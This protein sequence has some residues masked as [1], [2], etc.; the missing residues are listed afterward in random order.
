MAL[1][2]FISHSTSDKAVSDA[3]C[4][5]LENA[6]IRCWVAPRDV[7]PGRSFAGEITR[8]I[9]QSKVM[10]LI[11]S[12]HSNN[13]EQ[14]LRE[15]QLATNAHLHIVQFRIEDVVLNDDLKYFLSTPH[16]LDALSQPLENHLE[17]LETSIKSLLGTPVEEPTKSDVTTVSSFV[18][19]SAEVG[20]RPVVEKQEPNPFA[21]SP[22]SKMWK[23]LVIAVIVICAGA[24]AGW[25]FGVYQPAR[26]AHPLESAQNKPEAAGAT[27]SVAAGTVRAELAPEA[28]ASMKNGSIAAQQQDY[29]LAL[30][31]FQDARKLAPDTPEVFYNL[32][33]AESK[34]PERELRA[35]AWFGAY[36]AANSPAPNAAAVKDQMGVLDVRSQSNVLRLIKSVQDSANEISGDNKD[37]NLEHV[38]ELWAK[39]GDIAA[40][41][42]TADLLESDIS[43]RS[44]LKKIASTQE[45]AGD[46][47]G[48][49]KTADLIQ[50]A[51]NKSS[52]Q[53]DIAKAQAKAGDIAGAQKTADLIQDAIY[54]REAQSAIAEVQ[55]KA[56]DIAGAQNTLASALKT[57]DLIQD[58]LWKSNAKTAIAEAQIKTGDMTG[59]Q[60]T[61][62]SARKTADLIQDALWKSSGYSFIAAAQARGGDIPGAQKTADLIQYSESKGSAQTAIAEGQIKAGD[63]SGARNTLLSAERTVDLI[64][65][66]R[67]KRI[68]QSAIAEAQIK[69]GDIAGA[70]IT[71]ASALKTAGLIQDAY[72][73]SYAQTA[74]AEAQIKAGEIAGAKTTLASALKSADL[75]QD[76]A[77]WKSSAQSFVAVAYA[78]TGDVAGAQKIADLIQ[79]ASYKR[80]AQEAIA[81]AQAKAGITKAPNSTRQSTSD[82]KP[83]SQPVVT[84]SDWLSKLDNDKKSTDCPLN[85]GPFLDLAGYLKSLP[86]SDNPQEAFKSLHE[87]AEKI[88][89]AQNVIHKMLREQVRK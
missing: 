89:G 83:A 20:N 53:S 40:A 1:D 21:P 87:T 58:A 25:W 30:R 2:V 13:S 9:Q 88:V 11:F 32:G 86:P 16:W 55:I 3:V 60:K 34:I 61:L 36:L 4:A 57:A 15:V 74:I 71:L 51:S 8:A 85:T 14:V 33:L 47:A 46:F 70:K 56:G 54:K 31:F 49:L 12:A 67:N 50:D 76:G 52:A 64:R 37:A 7:Q 6:G 77:D 43:K 62:T 73:R 78:K 68:E 23:P 18:R 65:D 41:V 75:D 82:A 45:G 27:E 35:I 19:S 84:V 38:A 63:I 10:V 17:R 66:A 81:E 22:P 59:A 72:V 5:A 44:A 24:A 69:G 48:A 29:S 79:V 39:A 28:Q 42:K 26:R 80:S